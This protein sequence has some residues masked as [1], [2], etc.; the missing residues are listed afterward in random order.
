M[1]ILFFN[2]GSLTNRIK[3]WGTLGFKS[4]LAQDVIL[5]GPIPD[6]KFVYNNKEIPIISFFEETSIKN[7]FERLPENWFPDIVTCDTS[8]INFIPDIYLCPVKTILFTRDAWADTIY[9]RGLIELFDFINYGIVDRSLYNSFNVNILPLSNCAV[10]LPDDDSV[11]IDFETREIDV[12]SIANYNNGFYHE[13]Y[14]TLY[15]LAD[16]NKNRFNIKY[17]SGI[18]RSEINRYYQRSKI[19]LDWSHTLS[20][21]S[22]E[23]ALNGCLLFSHQDNPVI[24][25]FWIPGKEYVPYNEANVMELITFHLTNPDISQRII[26]KASKKIEKIPTSMGESYWEQINIAFNTE[27]NVSERIKRNKLMPVFDLNYRL[28]TPL[29]YNY[30]Y[31][32]NFPLNWKELY[33]KRINASTVGS[34]LPESGILPLIEAARLAFLLNESELSEHYLSELEQILPDYAWIWYLRARQYFIQG[35]IDQA[36]VSTKKA[37]D[38]GKKAPGLLQKYVLPLNEKNNSCDGRRITD[39]LWQSVYNHNNEFQVKSL[40]HLSWELTGD[41]FQIKGEMNNAIN[42]YSE[43]ISYLVVPECLHKLSRLFIGNRRFKELVDLIEN[44]REE[45][46]YDSVLVLY[47]AYAFYQINENQKALQLLKKHQIALE[48]FYGNRRLTF[49]RKSIKFILFFKL[50]GR[51]IIS[52][53][54][55]LI[56]NLLAKSKDN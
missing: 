40:F 52:K 35:K 1:K 4:I 21:R 17:V 56:L 39:Y 2:L 54:I 13:R 47:G 34:E 29:V 48:S 7:V 23:A 45:F 10:S 27:V 31:N 11:N 44:S 5:W 19:V 14:K 33:F 9:N 43:A 24:K 51:G 8:V 49:I 37:I 32:T 12:I 3:A 38:C 53:S 16:L 20:N 41:I 42:A 30:N 36:L 6:Q 15:T 28:T 50:L 25:E 46:P 26:N 18:E 22:Y 55:I